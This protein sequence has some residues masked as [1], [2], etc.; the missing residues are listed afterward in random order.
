MTDD[1]ATRV[2]GIG[3]LAEPVRRELYLYVVAQP[4]AVGRDQVA[5]GTGVPRHVVKF[6]LD[7]LVQEGLLETEFRRLSGRRGP[8]AG[9]PAKLYRRA[10][11]EVTV[12]LPERHYE[13]AGQI[14]ADAVEDAAGNGSPVLDAVARAAAAAGRRIGAQA[15]AAAGKPLAA[16]SLAAVAEVLA[17][18]GYE[19]RLQP[20]QVVL[21]N[22]PFHALA[23]QHAELVCTMNLEVIAAL[24]DEL[25]GAGIEVRLDPAPGRCCV[26]LRS[27]APS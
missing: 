10:A 12:T 19:P 7:K 16:P 1:F 18:H 8:G 23:Q 15:R 21:A 24:T 6:H 17:A 22:C 25:G 9:R 26:T 13:L 27:T 20:E 11:R 14:L 4:E 2:A 3:A 5:A